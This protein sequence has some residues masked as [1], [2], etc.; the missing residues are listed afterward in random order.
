MR[1]KQRRR[2]IN[3]SAASASSEDHLYPCVERCF[4]CMTRTKWLR[5]T[6]Q[7]QKN[8]QLVKAGSAILNLRCEVEAQNE[9]SGTFKPGR[10][11]GLFFMV[12]LEIYIQDYAGRFPAF[13]IPAPTVYP[14]LFLTLDSPHQTG[15]NDNALETDQSP[16]AQVCLSIKVVC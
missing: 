16:V 13:K 11:A 7:K 1:R 5:V 14:H 3:C 2:R 4:I 6:D 10:D 12:D 8:I 9:C 15:L